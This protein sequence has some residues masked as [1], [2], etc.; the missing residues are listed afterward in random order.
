MELYFNYFDPNL[1][2]R[3]KS[4]AAQISQRTYFRSVE[5]NQMDATCMYEQC[6]LI[7]IINKVYRCLRR[8]AL[9]VSLQVDY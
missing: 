1:K 2:F 8:K 3:D 5:S 9:P 6:L 7:A 4:T